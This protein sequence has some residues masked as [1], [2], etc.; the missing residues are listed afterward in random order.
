MKSKLTSVVLSI[1]LHL[2]LAGALVYAYTQTPEHVEP[3]Q[4]ISVTLVAAPQP[5]AVPEPVP[6]VVSDPRKEVVEVASVPTPTPKKTIAKATPKSVVEKAKPK[7]V[8]KKHTITTTNKKAVV[9]TPK[10]ARNA[11]ETQWEKLLLPVNERKPQTVK[12]SKPVAVASTKASP[13]TMKK[14]SYS[15]VASKPV[16]QATARKTAAPNTHDK[17][18]QRNYKSQ[19]HQLIESKKKYPSRAKRKG[20]E[21]VVVVAFVVQ[22]SGV[23]T[24]VKIKQSSG[25]RILDNAA[26]NAIKKVSGKLPFP[27]GVNKHQWLFSLPLTYRLR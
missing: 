15:V 3:A 6:E 26:M 7:P 5:K 22:A 12:A 11:E 23:I 20:D 13:A 10:K 2:G 19:L 18:A 21:G 24:N 14:N 17:Q 27:K 8:A 25:S 9:S 1:L 16:S 4:A